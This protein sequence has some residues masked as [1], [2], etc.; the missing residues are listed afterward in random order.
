M[1]VTGPLH[2]SDVGG[3]RLGIRDTAEAHAIWRDLMRIDGATG[4]LVQQMVTG[5]EVIVGVS[6]EEGYGHLVAFGLGGIYTEA[7]KDVQFRLAPLSRQEAAD[8]VRSV[9]AYPLIAGVRGQPGMDVARLRDVIVRV[10]LLVSHFPQIREM[11]L[12]PVKGY[13]AELFAVD[14]RILLG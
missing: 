3:V 6:R 9:H 8:M 12:N 4:C 5:A 2:K 14:A 1:K 13:G 7:L 10:S 11:D